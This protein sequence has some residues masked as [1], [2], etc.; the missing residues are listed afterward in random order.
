MDISPKLVEAHIHFVDVII[1]MLICVTYG[2]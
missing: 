2:I 1:K